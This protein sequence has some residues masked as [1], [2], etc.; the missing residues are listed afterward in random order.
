MQI[1]VA[2]LIDYKNI[3][4]IGAE[5]FA[6][7]QNKAQF[8]WP[9]DLLQ[10]ELENV[11]TLVVETTV[12]NKKNITSFLCYRDLIDCY[13]ISV[14]ATRKI[15]QKKNLQTALINELQA[16]AAL[17]QKFI[18]LEV[19]CKNQIA[20]NLYLKLG[21]ILVRTRRHYYSDQAD[22]LILNWNSNKAGC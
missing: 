3:I 9:A 17:Q 11:R 7:L 19:H 22:A 21:F 14:L 6:T 1:R 18:S 10:Q 8:N 15:E 4:E 5:V 20:I 2:T 12:E 16:I 13:E